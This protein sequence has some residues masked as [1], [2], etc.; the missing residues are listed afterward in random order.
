MANFVK[1]QLEYTLLNEIVDK[2]QIFYEPN[3]S[4]FESSI[5]SD[6]DILNIYKEFVEYEYDEEVPKLFPWVI[7]FI[8]DKEIMMEKGI[9]MNDIN[10]SIL[11]YDSQNIN[12]V[13]SDDNSKDLIGRLSIDVE[14][15]NDKKHGIQSQEDI[16]SIF[17]NI[18]SDILNN[19]RIKGIKNIRD[20]VVGE[21]NVNQEKEYI[22]E[23][24]G[25]NLPEIYT[26][27]YV[28]S[29]K[30]ISNDI[31]E[32]YN[33][34]G[35]E[36]ARSALINEITDVVKQEGEYINHRHIELLCDSM[37]YRGSLSSINRQGINKGDVGPLAKCS[38][39]DTTD[40]LIKAS[41]FSEKDSLNGVSSNIMLGQ[42]A[43]CGT[44]MCNVFLDEDKLI[45]SLRNIKDTEE[46]E[47]IDESNIDILMSEGQN[48]E[49]CNDINM[50]FSIENEV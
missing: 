46:F 2:T 32:I 22:L 30:T 16:L 36:A 15:F 1:N 8:F 37:T 28:N 44:G 7:R 31:N 20:I 35:I 14:S 26:C 45:N 19:V 48:D 49:Y 39:E 5:T 4:N 17:K 18:L 24:D 11:E 41:I 47:T 21:V 50:G 27:K 34:F 25:T 3:N 42:L 13:F 9:T 29:E 6:N 10:L 12:Y 40:Q 23:T 38:F 43:P 33:V